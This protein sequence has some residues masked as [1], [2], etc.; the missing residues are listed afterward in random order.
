LK[1]RLSVRGTVRRTRERV[2]NHVLHS[3]VDDHIYL[4]IFLKYYL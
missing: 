1:E 3:E 2:D 4:N